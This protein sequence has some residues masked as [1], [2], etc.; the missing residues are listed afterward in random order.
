VRILNGK[1]PFEADRN[2]IHHNLLD[3]GLT[4]REAALTLYVINIAFIT[5]AMLLRNISSLILLYILLGM[6]VLFC[7][8]PYFLK[9]L[10]R[11]RQDSVNIA[12]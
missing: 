1:S 2:H 4:H 7:V 10:I 11:P 9:M 3:L 6:A 12:E 5:T 8:A